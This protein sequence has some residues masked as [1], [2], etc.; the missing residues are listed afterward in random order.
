MAALSLLDLARALVVARCSG[1]DDV[2]FGT[3]LFG[4]MHAGA[5]AERVLG[6]FINSLPLRLQLRPPPLLQPARTRPKANKCDRPGDEP[7]LFA[8]RD[9]ARAA[10]R[11]GRRCTRSAGTPSLTLITSVAAG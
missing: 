8:Y 9:C 3:V 5:G 10:R 7:G 4:R 6:P 2:V 11:S 1:R